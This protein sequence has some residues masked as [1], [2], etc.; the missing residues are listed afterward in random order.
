MA[1]NYK[2]KISYLNKDSVAAGR[3]RTTVLYA[4]TGKRKTTTAL[5]MILNKGIYVAADNSW[6]VLY[7]P[8]HSELWDKIDGG[9]VEYDSVSQLDYLKTEGVDTIILD[10]FTAMADKYLDLILEKGTWARGT[11]YREVISTTD[12]ELKGAA[13][14]AS[15]D[16]R[17]LRDRFR[18]TLHRLINEYPCHVIFLMHAQFPTD[19]S[20]KAVNGNYIR[21]RLNPATWQIIA[22]LAN[23]V[24]YISGGKAKSGFEVNVDEA[25]T[26]YLGKSQVAGIKKHLD[27]DDFVRIYKETLQ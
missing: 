10:T 24:G 6:Q 23:I 8:I 15:V 22:E 4:D 7:D 11:G 16:Y 13:S 3:Y 1:I 21:P 14:T 5:R 20:K 17:L 2:D 12:P 27:L 9:F 19:M 25:S 18:P 26:V